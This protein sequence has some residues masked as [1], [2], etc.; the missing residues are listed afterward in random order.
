MRVLREQRDKRAVREEGRAGN[1]NEDEVEGGDGDKREGNN[2]NSGED[3]DGEKKEDEEGNEVE[4]EELEDYSEDKGEE[5]GEGGG[6]SSGKEVAKGLTEEDIEM[7]R[8]RLDV[9]FGRTSWGR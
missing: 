2:G 7:A 9:L 3:H 6:G 4:Y 8:K 5:K 1:M